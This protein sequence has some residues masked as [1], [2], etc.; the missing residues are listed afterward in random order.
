MSLAL[1]L[2]IAGD[3]THFWVQLILS[4]LSGKRWCPV[5]C[6]NRQRQTWWWPRG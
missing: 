6:C 2:L 3:V 1:W 5:Y 4:I